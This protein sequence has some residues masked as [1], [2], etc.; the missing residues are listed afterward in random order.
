[1]HQ[2]VPH[3]IW[4]EIFSHLPRDA[5][6]QVHLSQRRF[7][8]ISLPLLFREFVLLQVA[9]RRRGASTS[10][11][12]DGIHNLDNTV[13]SRRLQFWTSSKIAPCVRVCRVTGFRDLRSRW[14]VLDEFFDALPHFTNLHRLTI[15]EIDYNP[16]FLQN[17]RR[18]LNLTHLEVHSSNLA[19]LVGASDLA[20]LP[21]LPVSKFT[22][23]GSGDPQ[24]WFP[25][26]RRATLSHFSTSYDEWLFA[27]VLSGDPFPCVT[28]LELS[29]GKGSTMFANLRLLAKF[30]ATEVLT[31]RYRPTARKADLTPLVGVL[32]LLKQYEGPDDLLHLLFPIS[33][34]HRLILFGMTEPDDRLA[35]LRSINVPNHITFLDIK[36]TDFDHASLCDLCGL[37]PHLV[38]LRI[39][40]EVPHWTDDDYEEY[41]LGKEVLWD[42]YDFFGDLAKDLPFP[43]CIQKFVIHWKYEDGELHLEYGAPDVRL[44]QDALV[45]KYSSMKAFW[46]DSS[47]EFLYYWRNDEVAVQYFREDE[48]DD[49]YWEDTHKFSAEL[50]ALWDRI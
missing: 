23:R 16:T 8:A 11:S 29:T 20:T 38:D 24:Y 7:R 36:F 31:V 4:I 43:A 19:K 44:L 25:F 35:R 45:S 18:L 14:P 17:I 32:P 12:A 2:D 27:Q 40:V 46:A 3:E 9:D 21:P 13:A 26:L 10:L 42:A 6:L 33:S 28:H 47:P 41:Y 15:F 50:K 30:P 34:F 1:M 22:H 5:L 39:E 48:E 37:F 49:D